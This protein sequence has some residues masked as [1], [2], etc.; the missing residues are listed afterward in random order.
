MDLSGLCPVCGFELGFAP[1]TNSDASFEIC[2]CCGIQFG[3]D[4]AL[5]ADRAAKYESWRESWIANGLR[6]WSPG[7]PPSDFDAKAQLAALLNEFNS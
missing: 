1:W 7:K 2:P 4:D 3:Y 5:H 6:W